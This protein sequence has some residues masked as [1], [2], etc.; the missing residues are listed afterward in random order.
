MDLILKVWRQS[1]KN[2]KGRIETYPISD[3]SRDMSFLEI[4]QNPLQEMISMFQKP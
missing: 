2:D 3:I 4:N 1:G